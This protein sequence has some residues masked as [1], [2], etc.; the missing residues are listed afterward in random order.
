MELYRKIQSNAPACSHEQ[1]RPRADIFLQGVA[2][3]DSTPT[4]IFP[5][6]WNCPKRVELES[7]Y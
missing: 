7:S 2:G 1:L 4:Q 5:N 6:F 3:E